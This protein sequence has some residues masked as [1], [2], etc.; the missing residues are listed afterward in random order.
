[1][2]THKLK[3][4]LNEK[5]LIYFFQFKNKCHIKLYKVGKQSEYCYDNN[6]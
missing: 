2:A 5:L 6:K 1:M 4:K 3:T